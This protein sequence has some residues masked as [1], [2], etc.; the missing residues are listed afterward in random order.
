MAT[1]LQNKL[2][3]PG[4]DQGNAGTWERVMV[5]V[6]LDLRDELQ[7][8]RRRLDCYETLGIPHTLKA[9][10]KNTEKKNRHLKATKLRRV[11]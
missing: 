8:I 10:E 9:I 3:Q 6:L 4:D 7:A 11:A 2:W 5:A 1:R